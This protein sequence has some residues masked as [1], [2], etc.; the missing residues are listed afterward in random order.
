[1]PPDT[2]DSCVQPW[3]KVGGGLGL[4]FKG[5]EAAPSSSASGT[6]TLLLCL[7]SVASSKGQMEFF[8]EHLEVDHTVLA[9]VHLHRN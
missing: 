1:M 4:D 7:S 6:S 8:Q 9:S 2:A 5:E 3:V